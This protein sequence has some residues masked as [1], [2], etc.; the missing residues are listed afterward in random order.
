MCTAY[1][2]LKAWALNEPCEPFL[3][4]PNLNA[5]KEQEPNKVQKFVGNLR[6]MVDQK[7]GR[8]GASDDDDDDDDE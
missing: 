6:S 5:D 1:E 7:M 8:D 3:P 2:N 4:P